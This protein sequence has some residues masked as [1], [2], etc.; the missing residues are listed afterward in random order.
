MTS[1]LHDSYFHLMTIKTCDFKDRVRDRVGDELLYNS[2]EFRFQFICRRAGVRVID[3]IVVGK[4]TSGR[5]G[6]EALMSWGPREDADKM[7]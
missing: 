7:Q 5:R 2:V 4:A 1:E 6:P 3:E